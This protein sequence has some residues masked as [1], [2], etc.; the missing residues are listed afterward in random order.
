[1]TNSDLELI[2]GMLCRG[3][4]GGREDVEGNGGSSFCLPYHCSMIFS[5][6]EG[7]GPSGP[8]HR[9]FPD[10]DLIFFVEAAI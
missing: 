1:M 9:S 7:Q 8:S 10:C 5:K 3:G 4:G 6:Y 2:T